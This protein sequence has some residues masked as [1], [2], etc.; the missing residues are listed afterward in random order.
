MGQWVFPTTRWAIYLRDNLRCI[1]CRVTLAEILAARDENFLTL[2]HLLSRGRG[3]CNTSWNLVTAC[4]ECNDHKG[5]WS[6]ARFCREAG[7]NGSTIRGRVSRARA[8]DIEAFRPAA[9]ILLGRLPGL[10]ALR[11]AGVVEDHDW[12]VKRRFGDSMDGDYWAHLKEQEEMFCSTCNAPTDGSAL[13][14]AWGTGPYGNVVPVSAGQAQ[15]IIG[16]WSR[17]DPDQVDWNSASAPF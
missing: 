3:G 16:D 7:Y 14:P 9:K 1:Y 12:I 17:V 2:D 15:G 13:A 4:Y 5:S 6:L 8:R 11:V 10:P